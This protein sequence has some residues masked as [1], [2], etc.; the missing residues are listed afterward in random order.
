MAEEVYPVAP[1]TPQIQ[2]APPTHVVRRKVG[3]GVPGP[4]DVVEACAG[5]V[6]GASASALFIGSMSGT[7]RFVGAMISGIMGT[8]FAATSPVGTLPSEVGLGMFA[9]SAAYMYYQLF[10][11]LV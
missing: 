8:Y 3:L 7:A 10:G 5:A 1:G 4:R 2:L 9:T 11:Q 6:A